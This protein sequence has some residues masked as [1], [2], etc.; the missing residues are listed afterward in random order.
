MIL[1]QD[2]DQV[3]NATS[4]VHTALVIQQ[5]V[6]ELNRTS[7]DME[8]ITVNIGIN[9][10]IAAVGLA[11]FE[12]MTGERWTYTASGPVTNIAARLAELATEGEIYLGEATA[13]RV[14]ATFRLRCL[15]KRCMKNVQEPMLV[16]QVCLDDNSA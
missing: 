2:D 7:G 4:A 13:S 15:G 1:F 14:Q 9:S 8:P 3:Q 16:Y 12:G 6:S 5:Q 10:G 11:R